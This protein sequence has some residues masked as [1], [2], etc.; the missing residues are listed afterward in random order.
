MMRIFFVLC[1]W[2]FPSLA[3]SAPESVILEFNKV[4][5]IQFVQAAYGEIL[6]K[7]FVVSPNAI[8]IDKVVTMKINVPDVKQIPP[9]LSS[10]LALSG[11]S[12][13]DDNGVYI[14][15]ISR[16]F[17]SSLLV[18]EFVEVYRPRY[19]Q[20]SYLRLLLSA[21]D[22]RVNNSASF[23]QVQGQGDMIMTGTSMSSAASGGND[24]FIVFSGTR[25]YVDKILSFLEKIDVAPLAVQVRAVLVEVSTTDDSNFN[26]GLA[27]NLLSSR[28]GVGI[29]S[30]SMGSDNFIRFK[31]ASVDAFISAMAGDSRY[32]II[33]EPRLIVADGA[34]GKIT[35][36]SEVPVRGLVS[37]DNNGNAIQSIDYRSS[38]VIMQ[39][40]PRIYRDHV[41]IKL[42]Q[43][44]S[45]FSQTLTSGID[46]PTLIKRELETVIDMDDGQVVVLAGLDEQKDTRSS[47]G[48]P[49]FRWLRSSKSLFMI[50]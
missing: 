11:L 20:A 19:R 9:L 26:V 47:E 15:D 38:G 13:Q 10:I 48:L 44:V 27:L 29:G 39:V 49:F 31:S 43:Q 32:N 45:N 41:S 25:E 14:I 18:D 21:V 37:Y 7:N 8:S 3:I 50:F 40:S 17:E 16:S 46:S 4:P 1:F 2:I 34:T 5:V 24:D 23:V 36:G 28:L 42:N 35:V 30:S 12:V 6:G 22:R 33:T